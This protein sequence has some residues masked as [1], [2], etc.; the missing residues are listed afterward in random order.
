MDSYSEI[1]NI[2]SGSLFTIS[3]FGIY[4]VILYIRLSNFLIFNINGLMRKLHCTDY[5]IRNN[6]KI[7]EGL[8]IRKLKKLEKELEIEV[9]KQNL[10]N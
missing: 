8:S 6:E 2:V 10:L 3:I 5:E 7:L 1:L 9:E 4:F